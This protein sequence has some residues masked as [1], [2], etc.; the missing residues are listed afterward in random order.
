M[1]EC[2]REYTGDYD[3][4]LFLPHEEEGKIQIE[5]KQFANKGEKLDGSEMGDCYQIILFKLDEEDDP[6]YLEKFE[7]ILTKPIEY[8]SMLIPMDWYGMVC[9]KT[10]TS[11]KYANDVFDELKNV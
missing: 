9:R 11:L 5:G 6:I 7:A 3:A 2:F 4:I 8:I 1:L 10:T